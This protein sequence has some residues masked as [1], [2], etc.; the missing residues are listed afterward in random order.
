MD[1]FIEHSFVIIFNILERRTVIV[2][3]FYNTC[4]R[5]T[6]M[7]YCFDDT[8]SACTRFLDTALISL[9][10]TIHRNNVWNKTTVVLSVEKLELLSSQY[11]WWA[12]L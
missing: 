12:H 9:D 10:S 7:L 8:N 4:M 1:C 2:L 11:E 6:A 3:N 5:L